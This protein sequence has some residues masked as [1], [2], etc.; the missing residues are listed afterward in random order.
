MTLEIEG[1][2]PFAHPTY[3]SNT[4]R[5]CACSSADRALV[6]GT[7]GRGFE[8]LQAYQLLSFW[9]AK[10]RVPDAL[11][12]RQDARRKDRDDYYHG[13]SEHDSRNEN[14]RHSYYGERECDSERRY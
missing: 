5:S 4:A 3:L 11:E 13:Q 9:L 1:S 14:E 10:H 12:C 8:S 6:F 2:N 7:R